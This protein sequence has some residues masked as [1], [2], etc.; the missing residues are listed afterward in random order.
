MFDCLYFYSMYRYL[1]SLDDVARESMND[2]KMREKLG[3]RM[4]KRGGKARAQQLYT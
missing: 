1:W 4:R 3:K 2:L